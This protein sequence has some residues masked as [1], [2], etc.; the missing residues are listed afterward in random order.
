[1]ADEMRLPIFIGDGPED[2]DQHWFLCK[3]V[4][5][6]KQVTDEVVKRTQFSTAL[7]DCALNWYMKFSS[8]P[9]QPKSL[10]DIQTALS[11]EFKKP[12]SESQCIIELKEIK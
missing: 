3:F 11:V 1:M 10:N 12:K 5:S 9:R 4:W 2:P 7:R 8:R 6:I